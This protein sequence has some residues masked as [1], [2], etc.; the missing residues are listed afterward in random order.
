MLGHTV[1]KCY[2]LHGYPPGY[3][4]KGKINA[5]ANQVTYPQG[6]AD[7]SA[8]CP[9][10][11]AQCEQLLAFFNS[12]LVTDQ[13]YNHHAASVS[14]SGG[15]SGLATEA[16]GVSA[17]TGV[18][19]PSDHANSNFINTMSAPF[20]PFED[21]VAPSS[22]AGNDSFVTPISIPDL[23]P[24][25]NPTTSFPQ[26]T[27]NDIITVDPITSFM[28]T[29]VPSSTSQVLP[30]PASSPPVVSAPP[31]PLR[32]STRDIRPPAYLQDY[33]CATFASGAP[34]DLAKC[35]T[36]SHLDPSYQSYLMTVG[37]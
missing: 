33:A 14:T 20:I 30:I 18:S 29:D 7:A 36:Y 21:V 15:V 28:S 3:K 24:P 27:Y 17:A 32:K 12:G 35:L 37:F 26:S 19:S 6:A 16:C 23:G 34:Y 22:S 25:T 11:K 10:T 4:H 13:G 1:D 8:Q 9:I 31:M 5:S 2:K